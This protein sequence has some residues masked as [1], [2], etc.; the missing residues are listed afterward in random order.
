MQF[1]YLVLFLY[2]QV[3]AKNKYLC[4]DHYDEA[5]FDFHCVDK[6]PAPGTDYYTI[7]GTP[8]PNHA[9]YIVV[10]CG[11]CFFG[12][13]WFLQLLTRSYSLPRTIAKKVKQNQYMLQLLTQSYSI[14]RTPQLRRF[15]KI[16]I[17]T[18]CSKFLN[19]SS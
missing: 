9:E 10:V 13:Y 11:V 18:G 3:L 8:F 15:N 5:I 17:C 19:I 14:P 6:L 16:R 4:L 7:C 12:F 2:F 1:F